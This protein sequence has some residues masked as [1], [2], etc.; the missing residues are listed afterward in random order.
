MRLTFK[1]QIREGSIL[2]IKCGILLQ[3]GPSKGVGFMETSRIES[4]TFVNSVPLYK[5][6][7]ALILEKISSG[8][9][10]SGQKIPSESELSNAFKISR[11][12][13]RA[14]LD[15][16]SADGHL[17]KIRG[18]GTFVTD[19]GN[20]LFLEMGFMGYSDS[21]HQFCIKNKVT[22]GRIVISNEIV[23]ANDVDF[24]FLGLS[25]GDKVISL[26][27]LLLVDDEPFQ[28]EDCRLP[29]K[30]S[31]VN[32]IKLGNTS[33]HELLKREAGI[34]YITPKSRC[35]RCSLASSTEAKHLRILSGAPT[36]IIEEV[37]CDENKEIVHYAK[38]VSSADRVQ[39]RH[40]FF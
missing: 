14:A 26:V 13:V 34:E 33:L 23:P 40:D 2:L 30:Y 22:P 4:G 3:R 10:S 16:L 38:I 7:K 8:K 12:T 6:L 9:W 27:R 25:P 28:L 24:D 17:I 32:R 11:V 15:E 37:M 21:F 36:L 19:K 31:F 20:G 39:V 5:Q 35:I 1:L 18:K 29:E